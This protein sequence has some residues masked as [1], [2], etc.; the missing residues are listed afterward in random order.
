MDIPIYEGMGADVW[1]LEGSAFM[2][3]EARKVAKRPE[4][5]L[6]GQIEQMPLPDTSL[7]V[8]V[9]RFSLHYVSD[10]PSVFTQL[11]RVLRPGGKIVFVNAHPMLDFHF[12]K[13][14]VYGQQ[15]I[16]TVPLHG[17]QVTVS[18]PSHTLSNF[19]SP[20]F[21]RHFD[22]VDFFEGTAEQKTGN[23]HIP[24]FFGIV[25]IRR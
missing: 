23:L 24:T 19:L 18:Y 14:K 16:I 4:Q 3:G 10:I 11:H 1:G 9:G 8:I 22:L 12:Q 5:V 25:A 17:A 2:A 13:Q 6:T 21:L 7:D 15:E 20:N